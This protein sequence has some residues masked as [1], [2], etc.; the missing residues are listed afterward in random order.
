M[1]W[2]IDAL[3]GLGSDGTVSDAASWL[4]ACAETD[5]G[6]PVVLRHGRVLLPLFWRRRHGLVV[7]EG[8]GQD[9]RSV[10][11][12][13]GI[14]DG[15]MP[16]FGPDDL[17]QAADLVD[18]R[19][20]PAAYADSLF[21]SCASR[22]ARFDIARFKRPLAADE[23]AFLATLS[24]GARKDLRYA[25]RRVD[26]VFG[27][28]A[29]RYEAVTLDAANWRA[30]WEKAAGLSRHS[31]QGKARVSVLAGGEK[32]VFLEKLMQHGMTVKMHFYCLGDVLAAAAVT[33]ETDEEILLYAHEY[34]AGY[35]KYQ[36]GHILNFNII[37]KALSDG[38]SVLDFGV[39][40]TRH[41]YEWQCSSESL[42][43]V[44]VPLTWKG[45][46]ALA[47]QKARWR[48]GDWRR[49]AKRCEP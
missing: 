45:R 39:G 23:E 5:A 30:T 11:G 37:S 49:A 19:R 36:P 40:A 27:Q 8:L 32:K 3:D 24:S 43:R 28:G 2:T 4:R 31:W 38:I 33:M 48:L 34:H 18:I 20:F 12:P 21:P 35:A 7:A 6:R 29:A 47:Y 22:V 1:V 46:L 15:A 16:A 26:R 14:A 10:A 44:L 13:I 9:H 17:P 41:K 42:V 25:V